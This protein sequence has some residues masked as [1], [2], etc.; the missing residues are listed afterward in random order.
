MTDIPVEAW[1][2]V[3]TPLVM[4]VEVVPIPINPAGLETFSG[5]VPELGVL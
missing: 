1:F 4:V 2:A 5:K 3:T